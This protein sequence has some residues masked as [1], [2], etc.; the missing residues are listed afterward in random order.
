MS[1]KLLEA[2]AEMKMDL[3]TLRPNPQERAADFLW[4][5][6]TPFSKYQFGHPRAFQDAALL[7]GALMRCKL[8]VFS[9]IVHGYPIAKQADFVTDA[10]A[11]MPANRVFMDRCNG[12][13]VALMPGWQASEGIMLEIAHFKARNIGAQFIPVPAYFTSDRSKSF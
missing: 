12:C 8:N 3:S 5:L 13:L 11:W 9:P 6:A 4:Y 10:M 1:D 7:T 2:I